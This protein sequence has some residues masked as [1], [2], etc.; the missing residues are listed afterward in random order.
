M[1]NRNRRLPAVAVAVLLVV[2][3]AGYVVGHGH[4]AAA[5]GED[6]HTILAA[7]VQLNY[8]TGWEQ[9]QAAPTIPDLPLSKAVAL[10]PAGAAAEA[11]LIIGQLPSGEPGLLPGKFVSRLKYFPHT[12][13][14]DLLNTQAYMYVQLVVPGFNQTLTLFVIP[15]PGG[16]PTVLACHAPATLS[17]YMRTCQ[18]IAATLTLVGQSQSYELAPEPAYATKVSAA[19]DALESERTALR[20]ALSVRVPAS[21]IGTLATHLANGFATAAASLSAVE[22]SLVAGPAQAALA[23]ALG[24]AR[25][26]YMALAAAASAE[27]SSGTASAV[28]QVDEAEGSVNMALEDF[29]FLGYE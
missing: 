5:S 14:V 7:G 15:D 4:S 22:P 21:T 28:K 9:I 8:P 20:Q 1:Y 26:A 12:Q 11:G 6:A 19:V 17:A 18:Q 3:I 27:S 16:S 13:E 24:Q 23:N 10:A 25:T 29:A 2:A